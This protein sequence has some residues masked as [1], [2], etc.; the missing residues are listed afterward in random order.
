MVACLTC[1]THHLETLHRLWSSRRDRSCRAQVETLEQPD[2]DPARGD[3][4]PGLS[5]KA[6]MLC[7]EGAAVADGLAGGTAPCACS[8]G[9]AVCVACLR[10]YVLHTHGLQVWQAALKFQRDARGIGLVGLVKADGRSG[11]VL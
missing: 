5:V 10:Q 2:E 6:C 7:G 9:H 1:K 11:S 8:R 4:D 3:V